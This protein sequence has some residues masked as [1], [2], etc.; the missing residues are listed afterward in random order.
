M[1]GSWGKICH[2]KE[3]SVQ[4]RQYV[5]KPSYT[6]WT[7]RPGVS[8][9]AICWVP[10]SAG[11][12]AHQPEG[13]RGNHPACSLVPSLAALV[14]LWRL[15][16]LAGGWMPVAEYGWVGKAQDG[17]DCN[18]YY[19]IEYLMT[20]VIL[21]SNYYVTDSLWTIPLLLTTGKLNAPLFYRAD[22]Y[23]SMKQGD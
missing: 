15:G 10:G 6:G 1:G 5:Q 7:K 13:R 12:A 9:I 4:A 8:D 3:N 18:Q 22:N 19:W 16:L 2:G 11:H 21:L 20:L 14:W 17:Q 23:R